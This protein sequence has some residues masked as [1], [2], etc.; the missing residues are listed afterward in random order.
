[1]VTYACNF[2]YSGGRGSMIEA[3]LGKKF[4]RPHLNQWLV[5]PNGA[6]L[7]FQLLGEAYTRGLWSRLALGIKRDPIRKISKAKRAGGTT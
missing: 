5:G 3:S 7:S 2:R 6:H 4:A 1:M